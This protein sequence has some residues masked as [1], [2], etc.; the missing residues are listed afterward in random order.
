MS[1]PDYVNVINHNPWKIY[2]FCYNDCQPGCKNLSTVKALLSSGGL[3]IF[4]KGLDRESILEDKG[5]YF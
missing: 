5:A 4:R 1:Y 3:S 2:D